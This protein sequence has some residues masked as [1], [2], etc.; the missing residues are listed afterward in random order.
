MK[1]KIDI[2]AIGAHPDDVELGCGG[3]IIKHIKLG[4]NI[5]I[6]DLSCGELGSRGNK[7]IRLEESKIASNFLGVKFRENLNFEDGFIFSNNKFYQIELVK[8]IRKYKP[9]IIL[10]NA[11]SD[12]HPDHSRSA[13][14][15]IY[16]SFLSGLI[17]IE[18]YDKKIKQEIWSPKNIL[19]Y[20]QWNTAEPIISIDIS[21]YIDQKIKL[22]KIYKSQFF[23][24]KSN[25]IKTKISSK[26]FLDSIKNRASDLGRLIGTKY[27]E[28]FQTKQYL[29]VNELSNLI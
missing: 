21:Q 18:T 23:N 20:T 25:E 12:R 29:K 3:T 17:K 26:Q 19:H 9:D 4:Y 6:I 27:A 22:I 8:K 2:L 16:S 28:G 11:L 24:P 10:C 5:G 1:N 14:L 7:E 15:V 13:K